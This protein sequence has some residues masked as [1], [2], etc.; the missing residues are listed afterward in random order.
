MERKAVQPFLIADTTRVLLACY[1]HAWWLNEMHVLVY[2][3]GV[4][5]G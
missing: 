5:K 1:V 4:E 2:E 3:M